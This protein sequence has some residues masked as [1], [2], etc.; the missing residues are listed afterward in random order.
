V[1]GAGSPDAAKFTINATTGELSFIN[2]PDFE[3]VGNVNEDNAYIVQ[4]RASDGSLSDIQTLTVNVTDVH[5]GPT[6]I[7]SSTA[8]D[9]SP[10][11]L[12]S[13]I[14]FAN[15]NP[16][17][18][19]VFAAGNSWNGAWV[20]TFSN[21]PAITGAGT[22]IDGTAGSAQ[23][24]LQASGGRIFTIGNGVDPID[25]TIRNIGMRYGSAE[26]QDGSDAMGGAIYVADNVHLRIEN[27]VFINQNHAASWNG[28]SAFGG[29][30]YLG[31]DSILELAGRVE[32][33]QN[34]AY[35]SGTDINGIPG[36]ALGEGIYVAGPNGTIK[37][38][39]NQGETILFGDGIANGSTVGG[40]Q[41][42]IIDG[43]GMVDVNA[44]SSFSGETTVS[45][46]TLLV[47]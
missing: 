23:V 47:N 10:N 11:T 36:V 40:A 1:T 3:I 8:D 46:G 18:M 17:T 45:G 7:V 31:N 4:V 13:A 16:G 27:N 38:I 32:I 19:I 43:A 12:R 6:Y 33:T 26:T 30:I 21:L 2:A 29:A 24:L 15:A 25:V 28:G 41:M 22:I 42:L 20:N 14:L 5:E 44:V 39:P 37:L 35:V 34:D 9:T